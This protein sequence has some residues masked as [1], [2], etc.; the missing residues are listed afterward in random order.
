MTLGIVG[1]GTIVKEA[2]PLLRGCGW[3]PA[4]ICST[5]RSKAE[6]EAL[7]RQYGMEAAFTDPAELFARVRVDAI[8][9]AVP[10]HLHYKIA[11]QALEAGRNVIV[12][13]PMT[14]TARQAQELAALAQAQNLYL[15]EAIST[16]YLPNFH[17]IRRLLPEIGEVRIVSCNFSQYSRRYDEFRKGNILPVFDPQ[18]AGGALM[19]LNIYNLHYL[20]GLFGEPEQI[21]YHANLDRGIDTSGILTLDYGGFQAVAV[22]AKDCGAPASCQIQGTKGCILQTTTA[23]VCG[24][25][26][27][28]RNDGTETV[29]SDGPAHRLIPE[30]QAF[31][32]EIASGNLENCR[33]MLAHSLCVSELLTRARRSAGITFPDD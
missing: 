22:A 19:D 12:E 13:K 9:V 27:L 16:L 11:K 21:A 6:G 8:Y 18:K 26:T 24:A 7:C 32:D 25:V 28:R 15:F 33:K 5:P 31:A 2:L 4:V 1:T 20:A 3:Q 14:T 29:Y 23:N 30:F 17:T 10:N